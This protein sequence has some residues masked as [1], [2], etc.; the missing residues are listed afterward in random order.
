M[1]D[2]LSGL[3]GLD[4]IIDKIASTSACNKH[5]IEK[6]YEEW[7]EII[8]EHAVAR[9]EYFKTNHYSWDWAGHWS[10]QIHDA[11]TK[12][13][14]LLAKDIITTVKCVLKDPEMLEA[15]KSLETEETNG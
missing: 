14:K 6:A 11:E 10:R 1:L 2:D 4:A 3:H 12:Y 9:D 13:K 15:I 7:Q 5:E 8:E